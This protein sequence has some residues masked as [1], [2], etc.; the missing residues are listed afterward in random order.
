[1]TIILDPDDELVESDEQNN[2]RTLEL[3]LATDGDDLFGEELGQFVMDYGLTTLLVMLWMM[4]MII[5]LT[6][7]RRRSRDRAQH[8]SG[9]WSDMGAL[10]TGQPPATAASKK[11]LKERL[12][13][14][15]KSPTDDGPP[16]AT[17]HAIEAPRLGERPSADVDI[18]D[19]DLRGADDAASTSAPSGA[20]EPLDTGGHEPSPPKKTDSPSQ[21][22]KKGDLDRTIGDLIDDLL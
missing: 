18:S 13:I 19:L 5:G 11:S 10:R 6:S 15:G 7:W 3:G 17:I 20:F 21:P 2:I 14:A 12:G 16:M 1:V 4:I 9:Q 22:E 8:D